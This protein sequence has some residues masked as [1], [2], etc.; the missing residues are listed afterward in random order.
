[1]TLL[2]KKQAAE[3][4]GVSPVTVDRLRQSG[5][6]PY[7]KIG[8]LVRFIPEDLDDFIRASAS[9]NRDPADWQDLPRIGNRSDALALLADIAAAAR[10]GD[11]SFVIPA[12]E[13][14]R[15]AIEQEVV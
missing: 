11:C 4:L 7:R 9:T 3:T 2:D 10:R 5:K 13:A 6:L 1:M 8:G 14:L 15:D 12:V